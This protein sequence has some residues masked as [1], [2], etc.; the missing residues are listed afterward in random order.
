MRRFLIPLLLAS[1]FTLAPSALA[2]EGQ[3]GPHVLRAAPAELAAALPAPPEAGSLAALA[4]LEAV[5]QA[6]AWRS[7]EQVA[8]A[9]AVDKGDVYGFAP[10][11][12]PWFTAAHLPVHAALFKRLNQDLA[13]VS[14]V[15]KARFARVRPFKVE[16]SLHPCVELPAGDSY[17]SGH[18]LYLFAEAE[19]LAEI[20]PE[21]REA[22]LAQAHRAAWGRILGGV[23]F[24]SDV[25]GGRL[26]AEAIV[27][28]MK[29]SE[30]FRREVEAC[31]RESEPFRLKKAS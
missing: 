26:L 12:G 25:V 10:V 8:W 9:Q 14:P 20:Y 16:P 30:A 1:A 17:P 19:V 3:K 29:T 7:P 27:K 23:H 2:Q 15:A 28:E 4:D 31:R 6:Q 21:C 11:L 13:R 18:A 5:R 22:L 24:P